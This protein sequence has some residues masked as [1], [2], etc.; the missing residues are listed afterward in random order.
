MVDIRLPNITGKTDTE[1]L[2]QIKSYLYQFAS[3]LQWALSSVETN[4]SSNVEMVQ[5]S[6]GTAKKQE[7][8]TSNF[9]EL[10]ALII[11]SSDIVEA[12]YHTIDNLLKTSGDYTAHSEFGTFREETDLWISATDKKIN[13]NVT[14]FQAIYDEDGN[15]RT[16]LLINGCIHTGIVDYDTDSGEAIVGIQVGQT[17]TKNGKEVFNQFAR[18]TAN[19]LSFYD[20]NGIEVA[21]I[22]DTKLHITNAEI[23]GSLKLGKFVLDTS[24]GLALRWEEDKL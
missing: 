22:S 5:T 14:D 2:S 4:S 17:T 12:Y 15:I 20:N 6:S 1:Q 18:F 3:Q 8:P 11:K 23:S 13:Q 10:K 7:D 19:K 21:Y 9:N 24:N 16:E